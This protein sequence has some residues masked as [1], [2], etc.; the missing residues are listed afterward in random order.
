MGFRFRKSLN[1]GKHFRINLSK[2]GVGYSVGTKG[3]RLSH[4]ADGKDRLTTSIPGTGL[5]ST[6]T[7]HSSRK[8][9]KSPGCLTVFLVPAGLVA[10]IL[11]ILMI[12]G[13]FEE[14]KIP[15][16]PEKPVITET[17]EEGIR[18]TDARTVFLPIGETASLSVEILSENITENSLVID[19]GDPSL[20]EISADGA[21]YHITALSAG[22]L[23]LSVGTADGQYCTETAQII[24]EDPTA[25][26]PVTYYVINTSNKKIHLGG[27]SYSPEVGSENR[28]VVT[29]IA[30]LL[31][32]G[33][34]WCEYCRK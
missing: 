30:E 28:D 1:L 11:L 26:V 22:I 20:A 15:P 32:D 7:L 5:S 19:G 2:N 23:N 25:D 18:F 14:D 6:Q 24:I 29:G 4:G 16:P 9:S 13:R 31:S 8:K 21:V 17:T 34:T 33:Y 12:A 3:V 10:L 27:C